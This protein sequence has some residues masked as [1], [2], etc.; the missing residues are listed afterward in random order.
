MEVKGEIGELSGEI[1]HYSHENLSK[2]IEKINFYSDLHGLELKKE[3]KDSSLF[4]IVFKPIGKF[5]RNY[6]VLEGYKDGIG[7]FVFAMMMSFHS[8]LSWSKIWLSEKN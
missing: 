5:I 8:F 4:N 1:I 2:F 3:G 7:G 6:L